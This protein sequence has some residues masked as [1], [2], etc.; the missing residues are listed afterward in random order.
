MQQTISC[1]QHNHLNLNKLNAHIKFSPTLL[2]LEKSHNVKYK[3]IRNKI[4]FVLKRINIIQLNRWKS[5][6][7]VDH[8]HMP[9]GKTKCSAWPG[10]EMLK[11]AETNLCLA[12]DA[13]GVI[14]VYAHLQS[15]QTP[16]SSFIVKESASHQHG[17][18]RTDVRDHKNASL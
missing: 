15:S 9:P 12:A 13:A 3:H 14:F 8:H 6:N 1:S 2:V 18:I 5:G 4:S 17:Y 10:R 7:G 16:V 11:G